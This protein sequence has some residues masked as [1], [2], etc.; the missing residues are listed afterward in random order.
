MGLDPLSPERIAAGLIHTLKEAEARGHLCLENHALI[1]DSAELLDTDGLT[2][3][4]AANE[5][6]RLLRTGELAIYGGHTYRSATAR[7]EQ[8]VSDRIRGLIS[9]GGTRLG[10]DLD[11]AIDA[12][13]KKLGIILAPEQRQA[14]KSGLS[15]HLCIISGGPGTGKTLI[16][17][18]LLNIYLQAR[19]DAKVVCCAPTGRAA[20]RMEQCTG[21]HASTIHKAL[22]L[23]AG[24]DGEYGDPE[25]LDADL[26]L[27][28][29]VSMLDIYL[30][31]HLLDALPP[32]CQLILVGD[33]DQLPSVGPG[34]VLS[35]LIACGRIPVAMLDR[36]FR[37]DSGSLIAANA[38]RIRHN[39]AVLG[40]GDDFKMYESAG[41]A[42]SADLI[43][44]LY[45]D[46]V[47][48]IGVDNV[49]LLTPYRKKTETG[50]NSLNGRLRE[51][52]NPLTPGKPEVSFGRR[53][54]RLGDKVMQ[55][56]NK[57]DINNGDIGY[58]T[59][60]EDRDGDLIARVDFPDGRIAEY[61]HQELELL[62]LAYACTV[63][64]SQGSE[65]QSVIVNIQ[66]Q[67]YIMLKRPLIYTAITRAKQRVAIVG[68]RRALRIA[69]NKTDAEKRG[70]KLADRIAGGS[71]AAAVNY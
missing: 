15:S 45:L 6:F 56:K 24:D 70:T 63:H 20:R 31:R 37:Q 69:I 9:L 10:L 13:Q 46:E 54:F 16:Q 11:A 58:I 25:P 51:R 23:L 43:E 34:A 5:A 49:A 33:A 8:A 18:V 35:E 67:H 52:L 60:I 30:A 55:V 2:D 27:V 38:K 71:P 29:E 50:V 42:Q 32:E 26:V 53:I 65:Y 39:E 66:T 3:E 40:Y 1:G 48:R 21:F 44:R 64:K 36:V 14:V 19:P 57:N 47:S 68:D 41:F 62:E 17:N 7:A 12:E 61:G 59:G 4:M 22:G 28:D